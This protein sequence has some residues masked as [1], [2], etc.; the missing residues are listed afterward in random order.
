MQITP[1]S[2]L[3]KNYGSVLRM[4]ANGPVYLAQRSKPVGV[5]L[6]PD[7]Y[8]TLNAE[9]KRLQRIVASDRQF[10]SMDAGNFADHDEALDALKG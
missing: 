10:A 7:A 8:E 9:L 5:V 3:Q 4:L 1:V 2:T 6:S